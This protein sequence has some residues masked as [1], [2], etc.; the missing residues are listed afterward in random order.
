MPPPLGRGSKKHSWWICH[1]RTIH[2]WRR[3]PRH[4]KS[5]RHS[6]FMFFLEFRFFCH[7]FAV[8]FISWNRKQKN[9]FYYCFLQIT[10][11]VIRRIVIPQEKKRNDVVMERDG[12]E[13][14]EDKRLANSLENAANR[15]AS[16]VWQ[17]EVFCCF[18]L[19]CVW[20]I[21]EKR[22]LPNTLDSEFSQSVNRGK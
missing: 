16:V 4:Q 22:F 12:Q 15:L 20:S 11:K 17:L 14:V 1:R 6:D 8:V 21:K 2:W 3:H 18:D 9:L 10:R 13:K 7:S 19:F 5:N